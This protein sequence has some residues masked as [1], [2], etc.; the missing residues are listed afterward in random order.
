MEEKIVYF[1]KPG[2]ENT[3]EIMKLVLQR[4]KLR[5]ISRIVIA[6]TRGDTA[7]SFA[8]AVEGKDITLV[9][10]PWHCFKEMIIHFQEL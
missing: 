7:R 3:E 10:V 8:K 9:V 2:K 5:N 6:S 1:E 4:A